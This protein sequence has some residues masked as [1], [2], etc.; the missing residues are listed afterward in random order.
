MKKIITL[1]FLLVSLTMFS[2]IPTEFTLTKEG[3]TPFVVTTVQD[4]TQAEIYT[5][6]LEWVN[7]TF[8]EP[9]EVIKATVQNDYVRIEVFTAAVYATKLL[10]VT[11]YTD[12][13]YQ[14]EVSAKD[15]RYKFEVLDIQFYVEGSSATVA[16]WRTLV[17]ETNVEYWHK[18]D[19]TIK[20]RFI[21][22][23]DKLPKLFNSTNQELKSFIESNNSQK[24]DW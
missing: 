11:A 21:D 2:Q 14:I 9:S 22:L 7:K 24:N 5:K 3:L 1:L 4:K 19:G 15:N 20:P 18:K 23:K 16:G 17:N 13:K 6:T 12:L 8:K 10:G